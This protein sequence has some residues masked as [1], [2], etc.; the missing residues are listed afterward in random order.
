MMRSS[1]VLLALLMPAQE[2]SDAEKRAFVEKKVD[3][4]IEKGLRAL[5]EFQH[6]SGGFSSLSGAHPH[7]TTALALYTFLALGGS[8]E[9]PAAAKA[10]D[11]LLNHPIAWRGRGDHDTYEIS[12]ISVALS[13]S[14]PHVV[15]GE[16]RDRA[17][18]ML[19]QAAE[20]LVGAQA[21]GGGWGYSHNPSVW[22]DHSN[23]QFAVLGLRAAANAGVKVKRE[24]WERELSHYRWSQ[25]RNGGWSYNVCGDRAGVGRSTS[26]MTAAGVMG[27]AIALG[28][29]K[30]LQTEQLGSDPAIKKGLEAMRVHWNRGLT[31]Q[32]KE[33]GGVSYLLYSIERACMVTGQRLLGDID[34]YVE[35]GWLLLNE[36]KP[37]GQLGLGREPVASHCF[38][39]LFL[40]R[41]FVPVAT[42]SN[43][44][45]APQPV[46]RDSDRG[47]PREME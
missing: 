14:L 29:A 37:D 19:Q 32:L 18:S 25:L 16:R 7:G 21:R 2:A 28:S 23:S 24:V 1:I 17:E 46:G 31:R 38:S 8:I 44:K 36:Q 39:L 5:R 26:T 33:L 13:Y 41:A 11:W 47:K 22:H 27:L 43:S 42:P 40:K 6:A 20:W 35:G 30:S 15:K 12:L 9:E 34:W 10:L 45:P 3:A 4:A